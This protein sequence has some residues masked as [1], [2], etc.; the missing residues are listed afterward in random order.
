MPRALAPVVLVAAL[1]GVALLGAH[2]GPRQGLGHV[3]QLLMLD[4][5]VG[6]REYLRGFGVWAPLVSPALVQGQALVAPL[7][8]LCGR[9]LLERLVSPAAL[10]WADRAVVRYGPFAIFVAR[11]IPLTSFDLLS[12]AAGLTWM[13]LGPFCLAT[14]LGMAPAIFLSAAAETSREA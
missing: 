11:L 12:Y 2:P 10:T 5:L 1:A 3:L 6:V 7:P 8:R 9:P 13:R 14:G 4:D